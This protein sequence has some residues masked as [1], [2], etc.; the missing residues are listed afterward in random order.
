MTVFE[1]YF[2]ENSLEPLQFTVTMTGISGT[3]IA[4]HQGR[5]KY[6]VI[7]SKGEVPVLFCKSLYMPKLKCRLFSPQ[8]CIVEKEINLVLSSL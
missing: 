3:L 1:D 7:N 2:E 5:A 4:T 6:E 8:Q